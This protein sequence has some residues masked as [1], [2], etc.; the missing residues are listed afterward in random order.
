[1]VYP[2]KVVW[3]HT[4]TPLPYPAQA[5]FAVSKKAFRRAVDRNLLKRRMREAYRLNKTPFYDAPGE[6]NLSVM[7][8]YIAPVILPWEKIEKA[9]RGALGKLAA[10]K[11]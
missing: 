1:M 6:E 8:I 11:I 3:I 10:K 7:F 2:L 4:G 9:M 5:A